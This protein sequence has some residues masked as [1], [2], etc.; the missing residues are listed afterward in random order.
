M[1]KAIIID[2]EVWVSEVIKKVVDWKKYDFSVEAVCYDGIEALEKIHEIRPQLILTDIRM[3]GKNG[4]ELIEIISKEYPEI[5]CVVISGF[6]DFEY[7][8]SA[9]TYGAIGYLLKP[10]NENEL[11]GVLSKARNLLDSTW[12]RERAEKQIQEDYEQ[13]VEKIR[14]N[15]FEKVFSEHANFMLDRRSVNSELKLDFK[16][17]SYRLLCVYT[18]K[19]EEEGFGDINRSLWKYQL[20]VYCHDMVSFIYREKYFLLLNYE[21]GNETVIMDKV[22]L[23]VEDTI[24]RNTEATFYIGSEFRDIKELPS[25]YKQL[26]SMEFIRLF[27]GVGKAYNYATFLPMGKDV[28]NL[29][30]PNLDLSLKQLVRDN[31]K[32]E[33]LKTVTTAFEWM[34]N[35]VNQNPIAFTEG[36]YK[37]QKMITDTEDFVSPENAARVMALIVKLENA[38]NTGEI[39]SILQSIALEMLKNKDDQERQ[40]EYTVVEE[41]TRY[42]EKNYM[43]N[44]T[45]SDLAESVHLNATYL[46][47]LFKKEMGNSFKAYLT[48]VRMEAAKNLLKNSNYK[49]SELA[50]MVGYNDTKNF[51]KIFKKYVGITPVE[52]RKLMGK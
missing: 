43:N 50:S 8:K 30:Q 2:D 16:E 41:I 37:L 32:D 6:N 40:K 51:I 14:Q 17:G 42:I 3:P 4:L 39:K 19:A 15:F 44:I 45:L 33:L 31:A 49:T 23:I 28:K 5:L 48:D 1:D 52:Y 12:Q 29:F 36:V 38:K 25:E 21:E 7:A 34:L 22:S 24:H 11:E 18:G 46:S 13:T 27:L 47:E 20:P 35:R 9:L 10:I 26:H